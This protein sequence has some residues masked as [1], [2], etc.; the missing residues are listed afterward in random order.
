MRGAQK[1]L[2]YV[3]GIRDLVGPA[4]ELTADAQTRYLNVVVNWEQS[5]NPL[6]RVTLSKKLDVFGI[7]KPDLHWAVTA[8]DI[9]SALKSS[10]LLCL[11]VARSGHGR[12]RRLEL[13]DSPDAP[14]TAG[15]GHQMSTTLMS[16]DPQ[17]GVTDANSRVHSREN[18]F[19]G[20]SSLFPTGC[21]SY[22]KRTSRIFR[23]CAVSPADPRQD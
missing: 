13:K 11:V 19:I 18:L 8:A 21:M 7:P 5:A 22:G 1:P 14:L 10:E 15:G 4:T 17:Q 3:L 6:G 23:W 9:S 16:N 20:G 2:D 12:L